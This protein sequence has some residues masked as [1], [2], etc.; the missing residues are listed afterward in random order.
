MAMSERLAQLLVSEHAPYRLLPHDDAIDAAHL[1]AVSHVSG[2]ALAKGVVL[3]DAGGEFLMMVVPAHCQL[4]LGMAA[5]AT[6]RP[7]LRLAT[8]AEFAPLFPDC[9][10]GAMPPFGDLYG[11]P[12]YVDGCLRAAPEIFF[13]GGTHH[14]LVG[15][16]FADYQSLA[17]PVTSQWCFHSMAKAA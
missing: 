9:Q 12:V 16:R 13:R 6:G 5:R 1:A 17:K 14:E 4:D 15:M 11:L 3:R 7:G 10:L 8:E 2:R